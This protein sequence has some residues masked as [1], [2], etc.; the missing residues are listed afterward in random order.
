[1]TATALQIPGALIVCID[2]KNPKAYLAKDPTFALEYEL[3]IEFDWQPRL[4]APLTRPSPAREDDDRGTRHRRVRAQYYERDLRRYAG[5]AGLRLGDLY[6]NPDS[7]VAGIGLLWSKPQGRAVARRYIDAV[8]GRYWAEQ[9]DIADPIA[10]G[11]VLREV[12]AD[13]AGWENYVATA[14]RA[15]FDT[16]QQQLNEAGVFDVPG[17]LLDGDVFFGRQ[18][19]PMLRWLLSG[20]VGEPPL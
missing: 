19:L 17:Y 13:V 9:L 16:V 18:H 8:F 12:G 7:S 14:G 4:V 6:R 20:R 1:V 5:H 15:A 11:T 3:Q 10:I 2:F